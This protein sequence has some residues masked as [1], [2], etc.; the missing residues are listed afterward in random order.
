MASGGIIRQ[1][2]TKYRLLRSDR[3]RRS[4]DLGRE[5]LCA[6]AVNGHHRRLERWRS[7]ACGRGAHARSCQKRP[8]G[9]A[10]LCAARVGRP[11]PSSRR[12][13]PRGDLG[14]QQVMLAHD[15]EAAGGDPFATPIGSHRSSSVRPNDGQRR[16]VSAGAVAHETFLDVEYANRRASDA[17]P[18]RLG[19]PGSSP[20]AASA[21][22][23]AAH[24]L[25]GKGG[26]RRGAGNRCLRRKRS[27]DPASRHPSVFAAA[28]HQA[29]RCNDG[30]I[31]TP[32]PGETL[33]DYWTGTAAELAELE[34][35]KKHLFTGECTARDWRAVASLTRGIATLVRQAASRGIISR[36]LLNRMQR[37]TALTSA[38]FGGC[39][40][41]G[42]V[43][44]AVLETGQKYVCALRADHGRGRPRR[45]A[46]PR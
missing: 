15:P 2:T 26:G 11:A 9:C 8:S 24:L 28:W 31:R 20:N 29:G 3:S 22:G 10:A 35:L 32:I 44:V 12:R 42:V 14:F 27:G 5:R 40:R 19:V 17:R 34:P 41:G 30:E 13:M 36:A 23:G 45:W 43:R 18:R 16:G 1:V 6:S 39:R 21:P 46:C 37:G 38:L 33:L 25:R 4:G 7:G